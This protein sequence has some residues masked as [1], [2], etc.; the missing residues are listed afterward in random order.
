MPGDV[1]RGGIAVGA[2]FQSWNQLRQWYAIPG[3]LLL[4][5]TRVRGR[6]PSSPGGG[7]A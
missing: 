3:A 1:S 2:V 5:L 4:L 7:S 6:G